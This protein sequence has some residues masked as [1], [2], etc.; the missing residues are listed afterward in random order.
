MNFNIS[1]KSSENEAESHIPE[2]LYSLQTE[3]AAKSN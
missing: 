3:E 1:G 2:H